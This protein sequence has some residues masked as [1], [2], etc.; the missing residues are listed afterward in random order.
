MSDLAGY[1]FTYNPGLS[2]AASGAGSAQQPAELFAWQVCLAHMEE[3]QLEDADN[4]ADYAINR[5]RI[6][7]TLGVGM[8]SGQ[9]AFP[10]DGQLFVVAVSIQEHGQIRVIDSGYPGYGDVAVVI[11]EQ[12]LKGEDHGMVAQLPNGKLIP[13]TPPTDVESL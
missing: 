12:L 3:G 10:L 9:N 5:D 8:A 13:F 4:Y 11:A 6:T 7:Q 1:G 2:D